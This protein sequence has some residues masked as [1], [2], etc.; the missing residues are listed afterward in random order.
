MYNDLYDMD[1]FNEL[2]Y[3]P[4]Q[5]GIDDRYNFT[6]EGKI[7]DIPSEVSSQVEQDAINGKDP[8]HSLK[9]L[10]EQY[11][12]DNSPQSRYE[13]IKEEPNREVY[14]NYEFWHD[15]VPFKAF[16]KNEQMTTLSNLAG[17]VVIPARNVGVLRNDSRR[18]P[19]PLIY[20]PHEAM[21]NFDK[22][23]N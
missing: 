5:F 15:V 19:T 1:P 2:A 4:E 23:F 6:Y 11:L 16:K 17:W 18:K 7:I 13:M 3:D 21:S 10:M 8:T 14:E 20:L 12:Q 22:H 9:S